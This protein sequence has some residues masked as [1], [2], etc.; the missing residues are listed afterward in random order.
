MKHNGTY[1]YV[2]AGAGLVFFF[3][4]V[5]FGREW[6]EGVRGRWD[7]GFLSQN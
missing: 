6:R 5:F 7:G 3:F 1:K 4:P 2:E